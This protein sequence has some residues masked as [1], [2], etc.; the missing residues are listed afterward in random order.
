LVSAQATRFDPR[1]TYVREW[2]SELANFPGEG[3][4]STVGCTLEGAIRV[5]S[6]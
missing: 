6:W 1:G 3:N 2:V 5:L 4:P